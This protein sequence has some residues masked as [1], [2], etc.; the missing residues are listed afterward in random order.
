MHSGMKFDCDK[1]LSKLDEKNLVIFLFHGVI[2]ESVHKV[3]NYNKKHLSSQ[4][5]IDL[6]KSLSREGHPLS[7]DDIVGLKNE[8]NG[9]PP[10]SYAITFDDGFKNNY[11]IAAPIL[12]DH[13]TPAT[14]YLTTD[15][16]DSNRMS[17]IDQIEYCFESVDSAYF[18][19]P[20][21]NDKK[22]VHDA[23][24]KIDC[25]DEI[26]KNVKSNP[27]KHLNDG[28][29][30]NV[31]NQCE[32]DLIESNSD[33]IDQKMNWADVLSLSQNDFFAVGGHTH[34]HTSLAFL[35]DNELE[36]EI[37]T[38]LRY[39]QEKANLSTSHYSYPEGTEA[40]Y[41][42]KVIEVLKS[43][44]IRCCPTAIEG[45]NDCETDLFHLKRTTV[46]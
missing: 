23:K 46:T 4:N 18:Y 36:N 42:E 28:F 15:F 30:R 38:S 8:K 19:L 5:F 29:V 12:Y 21:S 9:Y 14:F 41:S 35:D 39:L 13:S 17:W 40:D 3:R 11:D 20:W 2:E 32:V 27:R 24:T 43:N 45:S 44:G 31:F 16:V 37:N 6:V 1:Y 25:L 22:Y 34:S 10:R 7:M 33:E 26:R